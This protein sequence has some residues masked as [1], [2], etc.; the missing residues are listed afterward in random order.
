M[1]MNRERD[2]GNARQRRFGLGAATL[3][4]LLSGFALNGYAQVVSGLCGPLDRA[5]QYGPYDYRTA[6]QEQKRLVE[7]AHFTPPVEALQ[8]GRRSKRP[9]GD[10]D[11][12]LRAFPNHLRA[13][14]A[15]TRWSERIGMNHPPGATYTVECYYERAIRFRPDDAGVHALYAHFLIDRK[16]FGEAR[17][18]L[19]RAAAGDYER[20]PQIS[21]NI[22]LAYFELKD[23][24]RSLKFAWQAYRE[25]VQFPALKRKL[26]AVGKWR[27]SDRG[28][29]APN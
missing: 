16:R 19:E 11:Y 4:V 1:E 18:Q 9:T 28:D 12:T 2:I 17:E 29:Q 13:L 8:A 25:G 21:Y 3:S 14:H 10:I 15:M 5:G 24:D 26:Q 27:E 22:G 23:Y 6:T 7:G 20:D